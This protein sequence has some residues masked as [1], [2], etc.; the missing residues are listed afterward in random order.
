MPAPGP[1]AWGGLASALSTVAP[2]RPLKGCDP[3]RPV[4]CPLPP[5]LPARSLIRDIGSP[6]LC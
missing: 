5:L 6:G 3:R 2:I 1:G 4:L